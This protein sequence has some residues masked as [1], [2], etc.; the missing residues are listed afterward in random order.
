MSVILLIWKAW[1]FS[2]AEECVN[3]RRCV[4]CSHE[5][6]LEGAHVKDASSFQLGEDDRTGNILCLCKICHR[7][8]DGRFHSV[9]GSVALGLKK[10]G[11]SYLL[12]RA[13]S[14]G[15]VER[16]LEGPLHIKSEYLNAKSMSYVG[17]LQFWY[18]K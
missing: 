4:F 6:E 16:Q 2:M 18:W 8:F 3:K 5:Y 7:E 11:N 17:S 12:G 14:S 1:I 10:R 15:I 9:H 13:D